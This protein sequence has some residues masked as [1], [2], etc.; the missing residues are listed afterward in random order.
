M[1]QIDAIASGSTGNCYRI[2]DGESVLMIEC[3]IRFRAI[4]E[5][6]NFQLSQV[7]GCLIS[8]EHGDHAMAIRHIM[9][10]G[11]DCY[12]SQGTA[13][14]L[15]I[16]GHRV[17]A[18]ESKT[19]F[20]VGSFKILPFDVRHDAAEPLGFLIQ[21]DAGDKLLFITDSFYCPY[22]F[23]GVNY[24]MVEC[25]Y[26]LDILESNINTGTVPAAIKN[27]IITS[28]FEL[29]KVKAFFDANDLTQCLE[30][31]L[32]HLSGSNSDS[33]LFK[34]EIQK[35]TGKPVFIHGLDMAA[36]T[37]RHHDAKIINV[38]HR[39]DSNKAR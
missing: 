4:R 38:C 26:S 5:A 25:N 29:E 27:R 17:H 9:K 15:G 28:H 33:Y 35:I 23:S 30:I 1:L 6:F 16:S 20:H 32:I 10:A 39:D 11:V 19:L 12:L 22:C 14:A 31:H 13:E 18:V 7:A 24:F 8:H 2:S 3:G 37:R 36:S 34:S 21:S